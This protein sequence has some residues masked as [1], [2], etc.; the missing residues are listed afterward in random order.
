MSDPTYNALISADE[1][2]GIV[3]SASLVIFDCRF[4]LMNPQAG[5]Q[6]YAEGHI[7]GARYAHLDHHLSSPITPET[8]RHPLP[9]RAKFVEW[10]GKQGVSQS[11]Q[12]IA[13]DAQG[14]LFAA[15][16]WWLLRWVGHDRV[17][18]VN[19][20]LPALVARGLALTRDILPIN[21][22]EFAEQPSLEA[23]VTSEMLTHIQQ[24]GDRTLVDVR[25]AERYRGEVEPID[26]VAGHVPGAI[27]IPLNC[28]LDDKQCYRSAQE[29]KA[30]Y[31]GHL[32]D[33]SEPMPILM[34]GS[35]VTA[36]HSRL[37]IAASGLPPVAIYPG[38]WSEWIR[39][40][41][42]PVATGG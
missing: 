17:A 3:D 28:A 23:W 41:A 22:C 38:S 35:G 20:G 9:D 2:A 15:R 33:Y 42:R 36:C 40:P 29:L 13:Y 30:I 6:A 12:V 16:L 24:Q 11:T 31:A 26:P 32:G 1:F 37:A 27:N 19:G 21:E 34:C 25:A 10:L 5:E 18:V 39:D 8:G 7:N 4:D 14:G